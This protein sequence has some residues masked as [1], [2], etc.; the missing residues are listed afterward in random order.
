MTTMIMGNA[1]VYSVATSHS[2][3]INASSKIKRCL[4]LYQEEITANTNGYTA[5]LD[6]LSLQRQVSV[7]ASRTIHPSIQ[8]LV[9]HLLQ[10]HLALGGQAF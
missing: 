10:A 2:T 3:S 6:P 4:K 5:Q 1:E 8:V 9:F 7:V